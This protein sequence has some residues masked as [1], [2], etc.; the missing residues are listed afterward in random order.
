MKILLSRLFACWSA[1]L[2]AESDR[3]KWD[4]KRI[5][6]ILEVTK[7]KEE[8][9][10]LE[11]ELKEHELVFKALPIAMQYRETEMGREMHRRRQKME[12]DV[13]DLDVILATEKGRGAA[14]RRLMEA[15]EK[16]GRFNEMEAE[17]G[18]VLLV[19][20]MA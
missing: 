14:E 7:N 1:D 6:S 18:W 12:R 3:R 19:R 11:A 16:L 9:G 10:R 15:E 17:R 13:A 8:R 4:V 20:Q 5:M 2:V